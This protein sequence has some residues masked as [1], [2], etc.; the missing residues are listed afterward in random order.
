MKSRNFVNTRRFKPIASVTYFVRILWNVQVDIKN[1][2]VTY[3][4]YGVEKT[5]SGEKYDRLES[6]MRHKGV[7]ARRC[8]MGFKRKDTGRAYIAIDRVFYDEF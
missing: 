5:V 3:T 8:A 4:K 1:R 6:L 2:T 7:S